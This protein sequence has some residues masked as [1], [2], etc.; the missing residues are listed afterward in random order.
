M[1]FKE[2]MPK[3]R[4]SEN[5]KKLIVDYFKA[6]RSTNQYLWENP[7]NAACADCTRR[8][9]GTIICFSN[10]IIIAIIIISLWVKDSIWSSVQKT[11]NTEFGTK[12]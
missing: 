12:E 4:N 5:W 2:W 11:L 1:P 8:A 7:N 6:C 3:V 10:L 9:L